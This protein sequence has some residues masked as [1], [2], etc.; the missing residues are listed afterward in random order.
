MRSRRLRHARPSPALAALLLLGTGAVVW[1]QQRP[2]TA[3]VAPEQAAPAQ[4]APARPRTP[5]PNM[6]AMN[7]ALGVTCAYCHAPLASRPGGTRPDDLDYRS[8]ANPRKRVARMM[9]AMTADINAS[10]PA[11]VLKSTEDATV[12][13]CATC[14][15]GV[16]DPRPLAEILTRTVEQEG[17][18]ATVHRY[19]ELRT[20]YFGR[21]AYDFSER[22]LLMVAQKLVER[23]PEA[24][25]A[26]MQMNL[27]FHPASADSY[28]MMAQAETRRFDDR[29]AIV[30]LEKALAIKP[31]HGLAQGY[32]VQLR[33]FTKRRP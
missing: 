15:R 18:D 11:A 30:H 5:R 28:V 7:E 14:H 1:A 3:G 16:P 17:I 9:V 20:R 4:S 26:L 12:V 19:R 8:E 33:Q 29:A 23:E 13:T 10:I 25:L 6:Q 32:L 21:D 2:S 24:A 22:T 31:D 27:E